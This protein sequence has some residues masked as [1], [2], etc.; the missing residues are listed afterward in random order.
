[1]INLSGYKLAKAC[2]VAARA[3]LENAC[4]ELETEK[5]WLVEAM[6]AENIKEIDL[7]EKTRLWIWKKKISRH[8]PRF[9]GS[10]E[11]YEI[12]EL[13]ETQITKAKAA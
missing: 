11:F 9:R 13:Q 5:A 1:M 2:V 8:D 6:Q 3:E 7:D 4:R 12:S 10:Q